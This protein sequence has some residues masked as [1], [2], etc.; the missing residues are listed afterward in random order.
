VAAGA[1]CTI[2]SYGANPCLSGYYCAA[3]LVNNQNTYPRVGVCT[4]RIASLA[5]CSLQDYFND[6]CT[7]GHIC[8]FGTGVGKS[9]MASV[10]GVCRPYLGNNAVAG[11]TINCSQGSMSNWVCPIGSRCFDGRCQSQ[12]ALA[13][14]Y[15]DNENQCALGS[16][17]GCMMGSNSCYNSAPQALSS[18][19]Q[20][21]LGALLTCLNTNSITVNQW[22]RVVSATISQNDKVNRLCKD[23][24]MDLYCNCQNT[25]GQ[26]FF[27]ANTQIDCTNRAFKALPTTSVC[28][29]C[30]SGASSL[31]GILS[32]PFWLMSSIACIV[33]FL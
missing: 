26:Y 20:T 25:A 6:G 7:Y 30:T 8:D 31:A 4:A 32:Y 27:S 2:K 1:S 14:T 24:L 16:D 22:F 23:P 19:C 3:N 28:Q 13:N 12:S 11:S 29:K 10:T 18:S 33:L 17:C 21:Y 15:C 9:S 5:S